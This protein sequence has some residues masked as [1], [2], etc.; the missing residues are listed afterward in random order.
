M[1]LLKLL[2]ENLGKP[3]FDLEYLLVCFREVLEE[4]DEHVLADSMPWLSDIV[5]DEHCYTVKQ[6]NVYSICYQL[7]NIVEVN[8]A[9]QSRRRLE[10][11]GLSKVNGLWANNLEILKQAGLSEN[12]ILCNLAN[13]RVEPV[14]TAHPTEAKRPEILEQYRKLYLLIVKR[15]NTM[16]T[17]LEQDEIRNDIKLVLHKLWLIGEIFLDKPDIRSELENVL[18]YLKNVFPEAIKILDRRLMQAWQSVGFNMKDI[19]SMNYLPRISF[20]TWV[21][22]DRDGHPLVTAETTAETLFV[23]RMNAFEIIKAHLS[24]L[25]RN[26]SFFVDVERVSDELRLRLGEYLAFAGNNAGELQHKYNHEAFRLYVNLLMFRLPVDFSQDRV[27]S[28]VERPGS[29][30][31]SGELI[32]D[33][34][35][36]QTALEDWGATEIAWNDVRDLIRLVQCIGFHL[37][38]L[39]IRQNSKFH[40]TAMD[41]L[42]AAAGIEIVFSELSEEK[43][44]EFVKAELKS[45]R[46]FSNNINDLPSEAQSVLKTFKV[47]KDHIDMYTVTSLGNIIVSMTHRVSDLFLPYLFAREVGLLTKINDGFALAVHVVPLFETID[48]LEQSE[49][50]L[51]EYLSYPLV[52]HSMELQKKNR[53]RTWLRQDVMIG[54][55]DSNKDGG[56]LASVWNLYKSQERLTLIANKHSLKLRFFHGRGGTISRGAGPMHWFLKALPPGSLSGH[57]RL[58]EQGEIIEKKYANLLNAA[59]N[60][61]LLVAGTLTNTLLHS[62]QQVA[63]HEGADILQYLS[64]TS[65]ECYLALTHHPHFM[66]FFSQATPIDV[67]E[68]SRIG[69]RPSRRTGQRTL[70][71]LRAIPWVFSWGQAR[72]NLTS[73]FGIGTALE[74]LHSEQPLQFEKLKEMVKYDVFIRYIFTNVD[75]G[76]AGTDEKIMSLYASLVED[77]ECRTVILDMILIELQKLRKMMGL[78]IERPMETRRKNH[79]YSTM[80]RAQ[81]LEQLHFFQVQLLKKWRNAKAEG[82]KL[83]EDH[84]FFALLKS[85]NAIANAIGNTG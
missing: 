42:L 26:L 70:N 10:A 38:K 51:D 7:L 30:R 76:L 54:Y 78:L 24:V 31:H 23:L 25:S 55:S 1:K 61:E 28:L 44:L 56:I 74:K 15:E 6:L 80:L 48:D 36:L 60:M 40:D 53:K 17:Q 33:L 71:D 68:S 22:G 73:W 45:A 18:H 11:E 9:V 2:Q 4:H 84:T 32:E 5:P 21:G 69:S 13:I 43:R 3:Y 39:D 81:P 64:D 85:I 83:S 66:V 82:D 62:R 47:L 27:V 12:E 34:L 14:L 79:F 72:Y 52:R 8:G 41:Q 67:I 20:G 75:T 35:I 37:A 59:Y 46:P 19:N 65:V 29:Y 77:P 16:Y 50:I 63:P 57:L 49:Q 58:T